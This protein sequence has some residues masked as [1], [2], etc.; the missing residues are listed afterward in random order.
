MKIEDMLLLSQD[1]KLGFSAGITID[2]DVLLS[3]TPSRYS[4]ED[5]RLAYETHFQLNPVHYTL[6]SQRKLSRR[7]RTLDAVARFLLGHG[8]CIFTVVNCS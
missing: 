3:L 4:T 7:F 8:V 1:G 2:N 6:E 5:S